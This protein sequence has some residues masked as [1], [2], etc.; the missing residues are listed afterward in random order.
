MKNNFFDTT[1]T[2]EVHAVMKTTLDKT[3]IEILKILKENARTPI[4]NI[5]GRV[6]ISPPTVA[7]RIEA[8]EKGAMTLG[9]K[10]GCS[11]LIK[12][13]HLE[14]GGMCDVLYDCTENKFF[15]YNA[16]KIESRNLHGTGCTLSSAIATCLSQGHPLHEAIAM[17]KNYVTQA[18]DAA[19]DMQIGQGPGPLWHFA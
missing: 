19:K 15:R 10:Y 4:K 8:M 11:V 14:E 7:A 17:A 3:D 12:G 5:A 13:G 6:F 2:T 16:P 18:I 9:K 1:N